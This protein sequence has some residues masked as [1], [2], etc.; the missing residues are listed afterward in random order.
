MFSILNSYNPYNKT[1]ELGLENLNEQIEKRLNNNLNQT[2]R[3]PNAQQIKNLAE[4]LITPKERDFFKKLFPLDKNQ[5]EKHIV[6]NRNGKI[7]ETNI[8]KGII[9]DSKA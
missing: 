2:N 7:N 1:K 3:R 5:L 8:S 4:N 6:F 9:I